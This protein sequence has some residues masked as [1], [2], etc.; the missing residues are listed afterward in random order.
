MLGISCLCWFYVLI[1]YFPF[2]SPHP[3]LNIILK[4][5]IMLS[6]EKGKESKKVCTIL[7]HECF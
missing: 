4:G 2:V 7:M 3:E 1:A 6:T 5:N